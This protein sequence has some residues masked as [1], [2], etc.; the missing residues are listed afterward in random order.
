MKMNMIKIRA[1]LFVLLCI[2][3]PGAGAAEE[4]KKIEI[5]GLQANPERFLIEYLELDKIPVG[6]GR[7]DDVSKKINAYYHKTGY[8]L[9][10]TF[11]LEETSTLLRVYVDEGRIGKIIFH[12]MNTL[13]TLKIRYEFKLP[14]KIYNKY[15]VEDGIR[16]LK[17][18]YKFKDVTAL[19]KPLPDYEKIPFQLNRQFDVPIIGDTR[20]P[21]IPAVNPRYDLEIYFISEASTVKSGISYGFDIHYT[22]GLIPYVKYRNPSIIM[23]ND[24]LEINSSVGVYYGFNLNFGKPPEYTFAEAKSRYFFAPLWSEYFTPLLQ[25]S[26]YNS[27]TS[28]SD[29]GLSS[30]NYT[31]LRGSADPG[32]TLFKKFKIHAGYG[33]ERAI[34]FGSEVDPAAQYTVD[35]Q[36]QTQFWNIFE[37]SASIDFLPFSLKNMVERK[38]DFTY[39]CYFNGPVFHEVLLTAS[40][41]F[42]LKNFSYLLFGFDYGALRGE[43]PFYHDIP[44]DGKNFKG[45]LG[46]SYHSHDIGRLATEYRISLYRD[47]VYGGLY[48]DGVW[49]KG[50]GYDLS[51]VQYGIVGG[52]SGYFIIY[53]QFELFVYYGKDYLFQEHVSQMNL[54]FGLHKK[55]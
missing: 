2:A 27:K 53:D 16:E 17:E 4:Y 43:S 12:K 44:V 49:F 38:I 31:Y 7:F 8:I 51:G 47:I 20:L 33:A 52:I 15:R 32:I 35:V 11:L 40:A 48:T 34:I 19:V 24:R 18:H 37:V 13:E 21:L 9:A 42:E 25:A 23:E 39:G 14:F 45:F 29:L 55:W 22:K 26:A 36:R 30:Y 46:K 41:G 28:R 50:S 6:P 54:S 10:S 5:A 1:A 3:H